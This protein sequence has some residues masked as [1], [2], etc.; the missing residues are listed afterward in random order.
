[1]DNKKK[2]ID[3]VSENAWDWLDN[4]DTEFESLED[5]I[6]YGAT[7]ALEGKVIVDAASMQVLAGSWDYFAGSPTDLA[8]SNLDEVIKSLLNSTEGLSDE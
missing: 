4:E 5:A 2:L 7:K 8:K 6:K 3:A 1:M